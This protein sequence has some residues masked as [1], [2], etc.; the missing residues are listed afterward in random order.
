MNIYKMAGW[1]VFNDKSS[2]YSE[3]GAVVGT[4]S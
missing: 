3:V 1:F 4:Y 2:Y